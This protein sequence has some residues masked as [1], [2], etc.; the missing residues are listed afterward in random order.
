MMEEVFK[1]E[2]RPETEIGVVPL[3]LTAPVDIGSVR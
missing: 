1:P 3:L 2:A